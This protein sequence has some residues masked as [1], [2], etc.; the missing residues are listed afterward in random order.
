MAAGSVRPD[1]QILIAAGHLDEA[2]AQNVNPPNVRV[3]RWVPQDDVLRRAAV[4]IT[5]GGSATVRDCL[6]FGVPMVVVPLWG[7]HFGNAARVVFHKLGYSVHDHRK[8]TAGTLV[9]LVEGVM[10]DGEIAASLAQKRNEA[11]HDDETV[12]RELSLFIERHTG[13]K[14]Q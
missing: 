12:N 10:K 1:W 8:L 6:Y 2:F 14:L 7:D 9:R 4:M 3:L 11:H 13:V 5:A